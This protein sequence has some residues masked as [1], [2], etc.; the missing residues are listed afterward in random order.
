MMVYKA[1]YDDANP[2][3]HQRLYSVFP[4]AELNKGRGVPDTPD[5]ELPNVVPESPVVQ[6]IEFS[7]IL[8]DPGYRELLG[9]PD[10]PQYVDLAKHLQDQMQ[11]VFDQ[12]PGF[13]TISVLGIRK[14]L[15]TDRYVRHPL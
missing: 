15:D 6:I 7:I 2:S 14:T 9:D 11:H 12:L 13:K 10:S 5:T 4:G 8:V 3:G 1:P